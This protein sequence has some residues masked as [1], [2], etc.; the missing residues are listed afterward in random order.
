M[1][2]PQSKIV[3]SVD[4]MSCSQNVGNVAG[5]FVLI[6]GENVAVR[7]WALDPQKRPLGVYAVVANRRYP[8]RH[9]FKRLDLVRAF[10]PDA[11]DSGFEGVFQPPNTLSEMGTVRIVVECAGCNTVLTPEWRYILPSARLNNKSIQVSGC[12]LG[13]VRLTQDTFID[14]FPAGWSSRRTIR[15]NALLYS[16]GWLALEDGRTADSVVAVVRNDGATFTYDA[17][18]VADGEASAVNPRVDRDSAGF[19]IVADTRDLQPG[20]YDVT[21]IGKFGDDAFALPP[22]PIQIVT[23]QPLFAPLFLPVAYERAHCTI[24]RCGP[25][26]VLQG[27]AVAIKGTAV[28]PATRRGGEVFVQF[29]D[30]RP[31]PLASNPFELDLDRP[32]GSAAMFSGIADTADLDTGIHLL[33][34][35]LLNRQS[36]MWYQL[37]RYEVNIRNDA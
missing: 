12:H 3:G 30:F 23:L 32:E 8:I 11:V 35:L 37:A 34:V 4:G 36:A 20:L 1:A 14:G 6:P 9:G 21:V 13:R 25:L 29:D 5:R 28:D 17:Q 22:T 2:A 16:E 27:D 18:R 26:S 24:E 33:R 10:G 31:M 19:R 15:R 7:G